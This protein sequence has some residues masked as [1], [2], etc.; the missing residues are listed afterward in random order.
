MK[1][2][3]L[4]GVLVC[5]AMCLA[6][7]AW[8]VSYTWTGN[9][10]DGLWST[11]G[12]WTPAGPPVP[13]TA[14]P[15]S[16]QNHNINIG[17]VAA[18]PTITIG[19]STTAVCGHLTYRDSDFHGPN[20]GAT[21]N[22]DGGSLTHNGFVMGSVAN[23]P[24]FRSVINVLN[25]GNLTAINLCLG[26]TWW[27]T[28][29][30]VT[31]NVYDTSTVN[32]TDY[33][34]LGGYMNLYGGT[35]NVTA[36]F[37]MA[38]N[39]AAIEA[40]GAGLTKLNIEK[41]KLV[42]A[43]DYSTQFSD[44][45]TA[46]YVT[47][48]G[49]TPGRGADIIVDTTTTPGST[50]VTAVYNYPATDPNPTPQNLNGT[51]GDLIEP[52]YQEVE[53]TLNWQ[54]GADPNNPV[55]PKILKHY[56]WLGN[57]ETTLALLGST[58]QSS[59]TNPNVS[60]GPIQLPQGTTWYW[61]VEEGLDDG[62]GN[63]FPS[64]DPNNIKGPIWVFATNGATPE[65]LTDPANAV[66]KPNASFTV[67][68]NEVVTDY[69]WYKVGNATPLTNGAVYS[70]TDT[71]TLTIT[72]PNITY[73]GQYYCV[74]SNIV[75]SDTSAPAWLWKSRLMGYWNF[76]D[77]TMNDKVG[78]LVPGTYP[79]HNG[80][81]GTNTVPGPGDA[82]YAVGAGPN[83]STAMQ[84]FNDGDYVAIPDPN[85]FNFYPLGF[86]VSYWYKETSYVGWRLPVSKMDPTIS[87]WLFGVDSG[88]RNQAVCFFESDNAAALW[89]DGNPD[90]VV[91]NGSWHMIT[92]TYDPADNTL[93]MFTDG[94]ENESVV[95]DLTNDPL[96]AA[97]LSIGGRNTESSISGA[98]DDVRI[99]S[100]PLTPLQ[101]AQLY[102]AFEPTKWVCV[103]D[104]ANPIGKYDMN[105]DCR[106]TLAD[107]AEFASKWLECQRYPAST[108][109]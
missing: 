15:P 99:Y 102:I 69:E 109:N 22:I 30:Y 2:K 84:F 29:P 58:P 96:P 60:Y 41:G 54:A 28:A 97:P 40:F 16:G 26:D 32:V 104:P 72:N 46:G 94:D 59:P 82:N 24:N 18:S 57:S 81:I 44:W 73:E 71:A 62:T 100:Y 19:S 61:S 78:S 80:A 77:Q 93:T 88:V 67:V 83:G 31:M 68:A 5:L 4:Q 48:Y 35:V 95:V 65:V 56:V 13:P 47:A 91:G 107:F 34:W 90:I 27:Y 55:N 53:L 85:F 52:L 25:G 1:T 8:A 7:S 92:A 23:N 21:L 3:W 89:A 45:I 87:G 17:Y 49:L 42:I 14:A 106:I 50:I 75:G 10:A 43:L 37:N 63:A 101:I 6:G 86:T 70:G 76:D 38:A 33:I 74:V 108:C 64:G 103:E 105:G 36:G 20:G 98:I 51:V 66:A 12:N 39:A 9:A 11:P 79:K